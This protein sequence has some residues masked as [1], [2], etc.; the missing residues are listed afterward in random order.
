[1][2][3]EPKTIGDATSYGVPIDTQESWADRFDQEF[4]WEAIFGP[5]S[6]SKQILKDFIQKEIDTAR[7]LGEQEALKQVIRLIGEKLDWHKEYGQE[8]TATSLEILLQDV[9]DIPFIKPELSNQVTK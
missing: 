7:A 9:G 6:T 2:N 4:N 5:N 1:M 8:A 3:K